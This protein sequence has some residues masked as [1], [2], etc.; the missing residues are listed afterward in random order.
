MAASIDSHLISIITPSL[1]RV[2]FIND[3]IHSIMEQNYAEFEHII[4]DGGST[5]G[6]LELLSKYPHLKVTS[7]RDRGM[8]DALNKG[9]AKI[10][11]DIVGFLNTDDTYALDCF[12]EIN[13]TF[14][15]RSI[16]AAVGKAT[17]CID[18]SEENQAVIMEIAPSN[19]ER[20]WEKLILGF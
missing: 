10:Q 11:G 20:L 2:H 4:I 17:I 18:N 6:T 8:Y 9:L 3:A 12:S 7:E 5:D 13:R 1:N 14:E 16:D 19:P 15:D